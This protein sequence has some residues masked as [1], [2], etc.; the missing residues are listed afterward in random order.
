MPL[1]PLLVEASSFLHARHSV[2]KADIC[3]LMQRLLEASSPLNR[4]LKAAMVPSEYSEL[5]STHCSGQNR[6]SSTT[7]LKI[8]ST[9]IF[10]FRNSLNEGIFDLFHQMFTWFQANYDAQMFKFLADK[11][12]PSASAVLEK[13]FRQA[14]WEGD[15]DMVRELLLTGINPNQRWQVFCFDRRIH[16]EP[17]SAIQIA[18]QKQYLRI[19][20]L[21]LEAGACVPA[22]PDP[23]NAP[24]CCLLAGDSSLDLNLVKKL[25]DATP[26][27]TLQAYRGCLISAVRRND[28]ELIGLLVGAGVGSSDFFQ[29]SCQQQSCSQRAPESNTSLPCSTHCIT[30]PVLKRL[31][32]AKTYQSMATKGRS[33]MN[34]SQFFSDLFDS[35]LQQRNLPAVKLMVDAGIC[36]TRHTLFV[37][38]EI[39]DLVIISQLLSEAIISL[40]AGEEES[41]TSRIVSRLANTASLE[42]LPTPQHSNGSTK[43][44]RH[45]RDRTENIAM[46]HKIAEALTELPTGIKLQC[47]KALINNPLWR[48]LGPEDW[49]HFK[50]AFE[51]IIQT[52][53]SDVDAC[54]ALLLIAV[55]NRDSTGLHRLLDSNLN[56]SATALSDLLQEVILWGDARIFKRLINEFTWTQDVECKVLPTHE[57]SFMEQAILNGNITGVQEL[58]RA[59]IGVEFAMN[60]GLTFAIL[61]QQQEIA[62]FL[63]ESGADPNDIEV[64]FIETPLTEALASQSGDMLRLLI[65]FGANPHD[66]QSLSLAADINATVLNTFLR[67]CKRGFLVSRCVSVLFEAIKYSELENVQLLLRAGVD[68]NLLIDAGQRKTCLAVAIEAGNSEILKL[69]IETGVNVNG[70][71]EQDE[72][73]PRRAFPQSYS[74]LVKAIRCQNLSAVDMLLEAGAEVNPT[75]TSDSPVGPTPL[76]AAAEQGNLDLVQKLL[77]LGAS[78]NEEPN[79][80]GGFTALQKTAS[81]GLIGIASLLLEHGADVNAKAARKGGRTALELAAEN[82]RID[83]V[84]F[85]VNSGAHIVGP[86]ARQYSE[87]KTLASGRGHFAVCKL[88]EALYEEKGGGPSSL[89]F[90]DVDFD[91]SSGD[92]ASCD[93]SGGT[94]DYTLEQGFA[95]GDGSQFDNISSTQSWVPPLSSIPNISLDGMLDEWDCP[96]I[97]LL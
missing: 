33:Q 21:L 49:P 38:C 59:G 14:V 28:L 87:A 85:L 44:N 65:H 86:D 35:C 31:L 97:Y 1:S 93:L 34:H 70:I 5:M 82:D 40:H 18:C 63:L 48:S 77:D 84:R 74:A 39:P 76:Q 29:F 81:K 10:L 8:M 60:G 32:I 67:A 88:L 9:A 17:K 79:P 19:A 52:T 25:I 43:S 54:Q 46:A 6:L 89:Q 20:H 58:F 91:F 3:G 78:A 90:T 2:Q 75:Q 26:T 94:L 95:G 11:R 83:M 27:T 61:E 66:V 45:C 92:S 42:P 68:C 57:Q 62:E 47:C 22:E 64:S 36:F 16:T 51:V 24:L 30:F 69:I 4:S 71:V 72:R 15:S 80:Y 73:G 41:K 96:S 23:E 56:C 12:D 53:N 37:L 7:N 50:E 13:L 55:K